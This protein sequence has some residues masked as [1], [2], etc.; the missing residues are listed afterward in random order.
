[1]DIKVEAL[2]LEFYEHQMDYAI[3]LRSPHTRQISPSARAFLRIQAIANARLAI[4][5]VDS[6]VRN[7]RLTDAAFYSGAMLFDVL[8]PTEHLDSWRAIKNEPVVCRNMQWRFKLLLGF[9]NFSSESMATIDEI[10]LMDLD[11][12]DM[13]MRDFMLIAALSGEL[14]LNYKERKCLAKSLLV[15]DWRSSDLALRESIFSLSNQLI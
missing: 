9:L 8:K 4:E 6:K 3:S 2:A 15:G 7:K 5:L 13:R 11:G 14:P 1:M 10:M 12:N